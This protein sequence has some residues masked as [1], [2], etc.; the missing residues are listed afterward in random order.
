MK[1]YVGYF[2]Q[3]KIEND[4]QLTHERCHSINE[5]HKRLGFTF[6]ILP[7]NTRENPGLRK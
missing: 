2:I 5:Y 3:M 6:E 1:Q 4:T 7:Q